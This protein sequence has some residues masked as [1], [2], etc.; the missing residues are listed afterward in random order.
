MPLARHQHSQ[1]GALGRYD[2]T[3]LFGTQRT[4]VCVHAHSRLHI[5]NAYPFVTRMPST[6]NNLA[7]QD[8]GLHQLAAQ[9]KQA[10]FCH[11]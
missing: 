11:T 1:V 9:P 10:A 8:Q 2:R 7:K 6:L 5:A 3:E 4:E